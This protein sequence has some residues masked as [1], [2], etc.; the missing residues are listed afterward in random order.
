LVLLAA[1]DD[2]EVVPGGAPDSCG[3]AAIG[4][5][6]NGDGLPELVSACL[7]WD[8]GFLA[9]YQDQG[10]AWV[11][12]A[13]V[14][15]NPS[16]SGYSNWLGRN[17]VGGVDLT[18]DGIPDLVAGEEHP[19]PELQS[20]FHVVPGGWTG[21]CTWEQLGAFELWTDF[22]PGDLAV[23]DVDSDGQMDL[24]ATAPGQP[25]W[26][27]N[28][29]GALGRVSVISE[30]TAG[31]EDLELAAWLNVD[32]SDPDEGFGA[33]V[34]AG[35]FNGDGCTDIAVGAPGSPLAD[36]RPGKVYVFAGPF[37][38]GRLGADSA[39][40]VLEGSM[41]DDVFGFALATGDYDGDGVDDLAI[42]APYDSLELVD[43][44]AVHILRGVRP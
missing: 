43:A 38:P 9:V 32:G 35:D 2:V 12:A 11:P 7:G 13:R 23:A 34:A 17:M 28:P 3:A 31:Q 37:V 19:G 44:G 25:P 21:R 39:A 14:E 4:A 26:N 1:Q 22:L 18:A 29:T 42:G 36:P 6:I 40:V 41:D 5:D 8:L 20:L 10:G 16:V 24:I 15:G 27:L 33:D 30:V